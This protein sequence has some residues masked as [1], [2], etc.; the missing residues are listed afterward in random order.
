MLYNN[1]VMCVVNILQLIAG[2]TGVVKVLPWG[3]Y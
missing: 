1:I 3:L 2:L